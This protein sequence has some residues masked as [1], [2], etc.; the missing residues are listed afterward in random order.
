LIA[1]CRRADCWLINNTAMERILYD[2]RS[3][4]HPASFAGMRE[5]V[6][7]VGTASIIGYAGLGD[8]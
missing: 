6:I 2:D 1:F 8:A 4:I 3:V 5:K 7:T